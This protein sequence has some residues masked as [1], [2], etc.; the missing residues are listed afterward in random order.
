MIAYRL[1]PKIIVSPISEKILSDILI[2]EEI[3]V[4]V[5]KSVWTSFHLEEV[6]KPLY[7]NRKLHIYDH[8]RPDAP[9]MTWIK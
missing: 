8:I 6:F 5:S 7:K 4:L 1:E 9:L 3:L 2:G